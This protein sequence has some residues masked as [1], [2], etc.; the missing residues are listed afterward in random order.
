M[1][2]GSTHNAHIL[3]PY[4]REPADGADLCGKLCLRQQQDGGQRL[5][6]GAGGQFW[7][8]TAITTYVQ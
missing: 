5:Y 4:S 1:V 6:Q 7:L 2:T 3:L 8:V